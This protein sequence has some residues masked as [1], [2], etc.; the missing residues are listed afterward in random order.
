MFADNKDFIGKLVFS[1]NKQHMFAGIGPAAWILGVHSMKKVGKY[2]RVV[3]KKR[4]AWWKIVLIV[5]AVI[6]ALGAAA[7]A[8]G[9]SYFKSLIGDVR[10]ATFED[11]ELTDEEL[12]AILGFVPEYESTGPVETEEPTEPVVTEAPETEP[13]TE[14]TTEAT[15]E[16][17]EVDYGEMGKII[18]VMLVGQQS[19]KGSSSKL[20][21]TMILCTINRETN[22][23]T[24]SSFLRDTYIQLPNYKGRVCGMQRMNVCYNLGWN[25]GGD[26]GGMEML[27]MLIM[28][29]FGVEVDYNIEI[30]FTSMKKIVNKLGGVTMTLTEDEANFITN[31]KHYKGEPVSAGEVVL[32]GEQ[33]LTYAR[34][35]KA[36]AAD[37]DMN[38]TLRQ[39][40][41]ITQIIKQCT[42]MSLKDLNDLV[43]E[44]VPMILTD[45]NEEEILELTKICIGMLRD[46]KIESNQCPAEGTYGGK[47]V[48]IYGVDSGVIVPNLVKNKTIMM[49]IAEEGKSLEEALALIED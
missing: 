18:N 24:M 41:L 29:N 44:V 6:L 35:R 9:W 37:N 14:P 34:I 5:L 22:T 48:Q 31:F 19:R 25:W 23:L 38:R 10:Q 33:A 4:L 47:I 2:Q 32:D 39:R 15:T 30:D 43:R 42:E 16:P 21:D 11:K 8:F 13:T 3:P 12:E 40:N 49:A 17:K 45:M 46:L 26:L 27:D 7:V 20:A 36:N 28:N 1:G